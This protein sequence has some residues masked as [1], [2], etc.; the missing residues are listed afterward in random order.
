MGQQPH[1]VFIDDHSKLREGQVAGFMLPMNLKRP[2]NTGEEPRDCFRKEI[3]CCNLQSIKS[4]NDKDKTITSDKTIKWHKQCE[5]K[6]YLSEKS[7]AD[8]GSCAITV[9]GVLPGQRSEGQR[10]Q[11]HADVLRKE[12]QAG[13]RKIYAVTSFNP[14]GAPQTHLVF[15]EA[16]PQL[17]QVFRDGRSL[18]RIHHHVFLCKNKF[19]AES[20]DTL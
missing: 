9:S 14:R 10:Q 5:M 4:Q 18:H 15:H 6:R 7:P 13:L 20:P 12:K 3:P 8:H 11:Q 2:K 16:L 1:Q 19:Q 17:G